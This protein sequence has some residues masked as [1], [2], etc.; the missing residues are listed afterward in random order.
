MVLKE[1]YQYQ[2][3]LS[4]LIDEAK[5]LLNSKS[6]VTATVQKHCR[7]KVNVDAE[8]EIVV[9][10]SVCN[11]DFTPADLLDFAVKALNEKQ[12]LSDAIV[13]AKRSTEIDIDAAISMNKCKQSLMDTFR[14]MSNIKSSESEIQGTDYK[15]DIN[16]EQKSYHYPIT[17]ETTIQFDR[18]NVRDLIKKY[19]KETDA[20]ST[21][22]DTIQITTEVKYEPIWAVGDTL[23]ECV[24]S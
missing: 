21:K 11:Y 9:V 19:R 2:N 6:F 17:Q 20:I 8:D 18:N 15:F 1:A 16:G 23:E 4:N 5:R 7:K 3:Y 14:F 22:L 24:L 10:K 13:E 12:K